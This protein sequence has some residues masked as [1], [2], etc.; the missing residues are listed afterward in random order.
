VL[1][2]GNRKFPHPLL[3]YSLDEPGGL[4]NLEIHLRFTSIGPKLEAGNRKLEIAP[5]LRMARRECSP[6]AG[7]WKFLSGLAPD[8]GSWT[9]EIGQQI[10]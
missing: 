10:S 5:N 9:L 4:R 3:F 6:E 8:A 7:S 1:E 2:A